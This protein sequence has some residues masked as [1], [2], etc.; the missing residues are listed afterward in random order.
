MAEWLT[1]V[2]VAYAVFTVVS[3]FVDWLDERWIAVAVVGA[4]LPDLSRL[5][6][7]V[8]SEAV[9]TITGAP[10]H[11]DG[12]HTVG[13]LILLSGIGALLFERQREQIRAFGLLLGGGITHILVDIPQRYADEQTITN[14]YFFPFSS[15]R[16]PTP[17][18]YVS[19]DRWVVV[20]AFLFAVFVFLVDR[21]STST[22][23]DSLDE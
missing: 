12:L 23:Q 21:Y 20:A 3:W 18:W 8:P 11:W 22:E 4:L 19:A 2:F 1:H 10:F 13:G 5:Q 15:W 7:F 16:A 17:G 14:L 9:T 6:L